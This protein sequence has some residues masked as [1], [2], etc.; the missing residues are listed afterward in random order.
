[1]IDELDHWHVAD[2][3]HRTPSLNLDIEHVTED[4]KFISGTWRRRRYLREIAC[5]PL[6]ICTEQLPARYAAC[7]DS[8]AEV[9]GSLHSLQYES[10][11]FHW[12]HLSKLSGWQA[13]WA[14]WL[15]L[16]TKATS[17]TAK[18]MRLTWNCSSAWMQMTVLLAR[19]FSLSLMKKSPLDDLF[20][21]FSNMHITAMP[22]IILCPFT[23]LHKMENWRH[24]SQAC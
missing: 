2:F 12:C 5:S 3:L 21:T 14:L 10:G 7:Q 24:G 1:M 6:G 13:F 9:P 18:M 16:T 4:V 11:L 23:H 15:G 17:M 20:K 22:H 19:S 8:L